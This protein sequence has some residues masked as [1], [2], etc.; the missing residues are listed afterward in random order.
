MHAKNCEPHPLV[1]SVETIKRIGSGTACWP[2]CPVLRAAR[3]YIAV[4]LHSGFAVAPGAVTFTGMAKTLSISGSSKSPSFH[5]SCW[6]WSGSASRRP[7]SLHAPGLSV[8]KLGQECCVSSQRHSCS[9]TVSTMG[10]SFLERRSSVL[11]LVFYAVHR[12]MWLNNRDSGS[13]VF[14]PLLFSVRPL[15]IRA[16]H[17]R[18]RASN[19]FNSW[20]T[21]LRINPPS[22]RG[23]HRHRWL[24]CIFFIG[25]WAVPPIRFLSNLLE[26]PPREPSAYT[27]RFFGLFP[28]SGAKRASMC[29]FYSP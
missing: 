23:N 21:A 8:F 15:L 18:C 28:S 1:E 12:R 27:C 13:D 10:H 16:L 25:F 6:Q 26:V 22:H 14:D 20:R 19:S 3:L 29:L 5:W 4:L 11:G 7:F 9:T 2:P 24:W 17:L